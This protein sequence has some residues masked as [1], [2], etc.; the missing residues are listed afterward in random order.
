MLTLVTKYPEIISFQALS[1][2]KILFKIKL[3]FYYS[4]WVFIDRIILH[5]Y[6]NFISITVHLCKIDYLLPLL[7]IKLQASLLV[8]CPVLF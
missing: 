1:N 8:H 6:D 7:T 4:C 5:N 3:C 2:Y